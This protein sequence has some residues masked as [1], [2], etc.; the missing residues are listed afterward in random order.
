[1]SEFSDRELGMHRPITRRDFLNGMA[2]SV[3]GLGTAAASPA[4]GQ[5]AQS[6]GNY[7]PIRSG[8]REPSGIV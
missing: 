2:V 5:P 4:H 3:A 7:P 1:M 8:M 6:D